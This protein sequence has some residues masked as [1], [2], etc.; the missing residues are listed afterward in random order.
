M[1][2]KRHRD[3]ENEQ[4]QQVN[5]HGAEDGTECGG[6]SGGSAVKQMVTVLLVE[7]HLTLKP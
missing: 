7:R 3:Q 4:D 1:F 2:W 5:K 6:W